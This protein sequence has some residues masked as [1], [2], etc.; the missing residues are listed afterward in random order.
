MNKAPSHVAIIGYRFAQIGSGYDDAVSLACF[1]HRFK[2]YPGA[3][4]VV[5]PDP[6][7]LC[8]MLSDALEIKTVYPIRR[9]WNVLAHAFLET[10]RN[11]E[12]F[13]S[14][15]HAYGVLYDRHGAGQA[16]PVLPR[17]V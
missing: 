1:V 3:I 7:R 11:P 2:H 8:E 10:Q 5:G 12:K 13:R 9:Y 15:D 6:T 4:L 16:F 17:W 14:L